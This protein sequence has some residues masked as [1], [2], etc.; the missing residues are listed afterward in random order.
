MDY[1]VERR[2]PFRVYETGL[3]RVALTVGRAFYKQA[4]L[5][6]QGQDLALNLTWPS[7][8][9]DL[10]GPDRDTQDQD[11]LAMGLESRVMIVMRR[12]GLSRDQAIEHLKQC[13]KDESEISGLGI[14]LPPK[15]APAN[16]EHETTG[17][18][19]PDQEESDEMPASTSIQSDR[20]QR[21]R[22][23]Y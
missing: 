13:V 2:E 10:P 17:K 6:T 12:F 4:G 23:N 18:F 9:I 16:P 11:S 20:E 8:T 15:G 1:A 7:P 22:E 3:A 5:T 19:G 14:S 21:G